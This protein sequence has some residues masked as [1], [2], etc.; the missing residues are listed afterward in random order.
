MSASMYTDSSYFRRLKCKLVL[1]VFELHSLAQH[2]G[3][4]CEG[5]VKKWYMN[6]FECN[7]GCV[8]YVEPHLTWSVT[9]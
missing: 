6:I 5:H 3:T 7:C 9:G 4:L 1:T 8:A 2:C